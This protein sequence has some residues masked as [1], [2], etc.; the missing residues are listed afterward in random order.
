MP[1]AR[2]DQNELSDQQM[3]EFKKNSMAVQKPWSLLRG[4]YLEKW[5]ADNQGP[6]KRRARCLNPQHTAS[7]PREPT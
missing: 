2:K 3:K 4:R 1:W 7:P 5:V 6:P